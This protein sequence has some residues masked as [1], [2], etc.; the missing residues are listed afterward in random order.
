MGVGRV[1][2]KR[3]GE[4]REG[5]ESHVTVGLPLSVAFDRTDAV[6]GVGDEE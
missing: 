2:R 6:H 1:E 4:G 5:A 3:G